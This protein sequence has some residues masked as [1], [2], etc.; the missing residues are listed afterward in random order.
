MVVLLCLT[1]VLG[2]ILL[3]EHIINGSQWHKRKVNKANQEA[4][5]QVAILKKRAKKYAERQVSLLYQDE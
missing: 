5:K 1:A 2:S 4:A 3:V